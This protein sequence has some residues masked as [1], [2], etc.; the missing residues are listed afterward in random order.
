[1]TI[2][3]CVELLAQADATIQDNTTGDITAA[4]VRA[5]FKDIVDTFTPAYGAIL[6]GSTETLSATPTV[7]APAISQLVATAGY[8]TT[9]LTNG[10]VTRTMG[11]VVGGTEQVIIGGE[12]EGAN[13]N[14]VRVELYRDGA[15][16]SYYMDVTCRGAGRPVGF[17]I[18]GILYHEGDTTYDIRATGDA[19]SYVFSDVRLIA[20]AQAVRSFV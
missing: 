5:L 11:G 16:T 3:S 4:E 1:M 19:G 17:N 20:Q 6:L 8:F 15:P 14:L 9:N 10:S 13:N 12:V 18:A 7:L 2:K